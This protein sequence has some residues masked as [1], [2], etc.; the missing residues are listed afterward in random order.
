MVRQVHL[1]QLVYLVLLVLLVVKVHEVLKVFKVGLVLLAWLVLVLK[2][3]AD[4]KANLVQKVYPVS[5]VNRAHAELK[6]TLVHWVELDTMVEI[7]PALKVVKVN[8]VSLVVK[9]IQ[10]LTNVVQWVKPVL[11]VK[12]KSLKLRKSAARL[13]N[14]LI[15][16][17]TLVFLV[18]LK[19]TMNLLNSMLLQLM[20]GMVI[21]QKQVPLL[22]LLMVFIIFRQ[23]PS[24]ANHPANSTSTSYTTAKSYPPPQISTKHLKPSQPP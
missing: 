13:L 12:V 6:V 5:K 17:S 14:Q 8:K 1:V 4:P 11:V 9:V 10:V 15:S 3:N 16:T 24:A 22:H 7:L 18:I 20:P 21:C 23:T 19:D 2:V